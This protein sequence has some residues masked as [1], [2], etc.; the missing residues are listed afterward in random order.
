[1][2]GRLNFNFT[3]RLANKNY[4]FLIIGP[5]LKKCSIYVVNDFMQKRDINKL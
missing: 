4:E 3:G 2:G 1:M 5:C